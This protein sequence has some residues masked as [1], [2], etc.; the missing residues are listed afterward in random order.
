MSLPSSSSHFQ[1]RLLL[2]TF[3]PTGKLICMK[4][5]Y[6]SNFRRIY[7]PYV[8]TEEF[9]AFFVGMYYI[10]TCISDWDGVRIGNCI[11]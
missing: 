11:Y 3:R 7:A 9:D 5:V 6:V 2:Y 8:N 4:A 10:V 1:V